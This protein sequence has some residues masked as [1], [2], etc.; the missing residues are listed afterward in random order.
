MT[1]YEMCNDKMPL[2]I[3]NTGSRMCENAG[4]LVRGKTGSVQT[5]KTVFSIQRSIPQTQR[6]PPS[7]RLYHTAL[8]SNGRFT[9]FSTAKIMP[10]PV[11][12]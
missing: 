9:L 7:P 12:A 5:M 1:L 8:T 10:H 2:Q 6:A 4:S 3:D 11:A